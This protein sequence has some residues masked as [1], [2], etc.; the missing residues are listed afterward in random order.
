MSHES[1]QK[2][3]VLIKAA[4]SLDGKIATK[5][6][7]SQWI[8]NEKSRAYVHQLRSEYD[9]ILVGATTVILDDPKLTIRIKGQ[10]ERSSI[11]LILDSQGRTPLSSTVYN[12]A[13][14]DKTILVVT[15]AISQEKEDAFRQHGIR[16]L[17]VKSKNGRIDFKDLCDQCARI[18]IKSIFIEGGGEIIASALQAGI[19]DRVTV[20]IAPLLIG[21]G[22]AKGFMAGEGIESLKDAIHL[23]QPT[24]Q[25][26]DEDLILTYDVIQKESI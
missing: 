4:I 20:A 24:L 26:M 15:Q 2:P 7:E 17:K 23:T 8:S 13:F 10:A 1:I 6:G 21:G 19:V 3:F 16:I 9:S 11:R 14:K 5:T 25:W 18:H 22:G 12:D